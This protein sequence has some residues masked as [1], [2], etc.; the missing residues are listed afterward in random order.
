MDAGSLA[1]PC[2]TGSLHPAQCR[3]A[4]DRTTLPLSSLQQI[5]RVHAILL[6]HGARLAA[7]SGLIFTLLSTFP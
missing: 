3:S 1:V 6:H 2:C 4:A 5:A 7:N